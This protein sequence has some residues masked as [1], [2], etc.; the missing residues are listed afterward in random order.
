M[1]K[2][3][4]TEAEAEAKSG[5]RSLKC[6]KAEKV[7]CVVTPCRRL[8]IQVLKTGEKGGRRRRRRKGKKKKQG[9]YARQRST[10]FFL[11]VLEAVRGSLSPRQRAADAMAAVLTVISRV[12]SSNRE[13]EVTV[14]RD[15]VRSAGAPAGI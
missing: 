14:L 7:K 8:Q 1:Q 5:T 6:C 13:E 4:K 11:S 12:V 15:A 9:S 3:P 10:R 2:P